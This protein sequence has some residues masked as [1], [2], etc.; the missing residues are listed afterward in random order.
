MRSLRTEASRSLVVQEQ[1][2]QCEQTVGGVDVSFERPLSYVQ[3]NHWKAPWN[4]KVASFIKQQ[5]Q[6][7][8]R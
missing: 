1:I 6:H 7:A 5:Q 4:L 3:T 8:P 2:L